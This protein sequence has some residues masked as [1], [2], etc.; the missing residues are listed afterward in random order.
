MLQQILEI[1]ILSSH[2]G[3][4]SCVCVCVLGLSTCV[5]C[6]EKYLIITYIYLN[7]LANFILFGNSSGTAN[8]LHLSVGSNRLSTPIVLLD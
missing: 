3:L 6:S 5:R 7:I 1:T 8:A 4:L 2:L